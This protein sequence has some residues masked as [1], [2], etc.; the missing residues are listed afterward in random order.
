MIFAILMTT[1]FAIGAVSAIFDSANA[2]ILQRE[3]K[4]DRT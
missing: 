3:M 4:N 2:D 1:A